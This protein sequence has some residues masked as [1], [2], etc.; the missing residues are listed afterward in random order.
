M[1]GPD[2]STVGL[3]RL[4][5]DDLPLMRAFTECMGRVFDDPQTYTGQPPDDGYLTRLLANES[6]VAI[7]ALSD[8]EVIGA[9][10]AYELPKYE[11]ARSEIYLYDLAVVP[12]HRRRGV[13]SALIRELRRIGRERGAWVVFVQADTGVEDAAAI[14]LYS[15]LGNREEVLHFDIPIEDGEGSR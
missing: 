14:A 10:A 1:A 4:G 11:R 3:V 9:L 7:A 2:A 13:A 15:K 12:E 6:F 5:A 8:G